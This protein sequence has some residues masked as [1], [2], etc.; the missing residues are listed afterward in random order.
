MAKF[1]AN[2]NESFG[3]I[4]SALNKSLKKYGNKNNFKRT[5]SNVSSASWD[6]SANKVRKK[7]FTPKPKN[8][9][10]N[11]LIAERRKLPIFSVKQKIIEAL[12]TEDTIIFIGETASGKTTQIPQFMHEAKINGIKAIAITQPRRVA[13]ISVAQ[14]VAKEMNSELG[15]VVGYSVRFEE[16]CSDRT[17]LKYMT[18]G[19]LL[20]EAISDPNL[21]KYSIIVLDEAHERSV[22]TDLL[23][24]IVKRAQKLRK[25]IN[26]CPLKVVVMSA[27]MDVDHFSKY[28][29]NANVY[30][31]SGR[32]FPIKIK[33]TTQEH[34]DY[35]HAALITVFQIHQNEEKG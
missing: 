16:K 23:F 4:S 25:V 15:F 3:N 33:Y 14:R 8:L 1:N 18:D 35:V 29:D 10:P 34:E 9:H 21:N 6:E 20:R 19:M 12:K 26:K 5:L 11:V 13:A 22:Q 30:Y 2:Q 7:E 17:V 28:F 27:S 24:G 31:L 32:Q